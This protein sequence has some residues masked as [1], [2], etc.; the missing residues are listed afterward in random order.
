MKTRIV[1]AFPPEKLYLCF[2]LI[3]TATNVL[4]CHYIEVLKTSIITVL[5]AI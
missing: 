5:L 3:K 4:I 2:F 1:K